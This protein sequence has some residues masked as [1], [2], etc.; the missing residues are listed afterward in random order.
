MLSSDLAV[1]P[2]PTSQA[3]IERGT[4]TSTSTTTGTTS[5]APVKRVVDRDH[6]PGQF[7]LTGSVRAQ[8]T[9]ETWAGTGR[10]VTVSMYPVAERELRGAP[11]PD[12][13][14]FL[15]RLANSGLDDLDVPPDP[16]VIDD[17]ISLALRGGF[18]GITY[19]ERSARTRSVWLES[20]IDNLVTRDAAI[21][22][23]A[24]DPVKL[25][26][27]LSVLALNNAGLPSEATIYRAA[28]V[29]AKTAAGY[30]RLLTNLFVLEA[31][32]AWANNRLTRLVKHAKRYLIDTGLAAVAAGLDAPTILRSADLVG[33]CFD[34]FPTAQLRP[35]FA[36]SHPRPLAHHLRLEGGRREIDLVVENGGSR[37]VALEFKA[38]G[39]PSSHDARHLA[40]L[41]DQ[42]GEGFVAGAVIHAGPALYQLG[43]RVYAV[44]LCS[45]WS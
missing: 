5:L 19:Q 20:Y 35:E 22:D 12:Q 43:D 39:A 36:L 9:T 37:V 4:A 3:G 8:L 16:P 24:K 45:L 28:D 27:Y 31:V 26:R 2:T 23:T 10:I 7:I 14:S 21:A 44:P 32:P 41:R 38:G 30:D 40:W 25:R 17:Y 29:N 11:D 34:A 33:R 13:P 1:R 6:S 15:T 18:P 42:L